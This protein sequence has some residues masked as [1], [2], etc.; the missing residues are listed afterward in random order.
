MSK[1]P[2][3][4]SA[5][6]L[7]SWSDSVCGEFESGY[8]LACEFSWN[9]CTLEIKPMDAVV[10]VNG[11]EFDI[12]ITN[13]GKFYPESDFF[14]GIDFKVLYGQMDLE[15]CDFFTEKDYRAYQ[16]ARGVMIHRSHDGLESQ[17]QAIAK[18][19]FEGMAESGF[20]Y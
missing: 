7:M 8:C 4:Q 18:E 1:C 10:E 11:I 20:S 15:K 6:A 12:Q 17:I 19:H 3:C 2:K 13:W 16:V 14:Q 5:G 9:N